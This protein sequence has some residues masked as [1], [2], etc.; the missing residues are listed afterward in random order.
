MPRNV[1][2]YDE[3]C[4]QEKYLWFL[5]EEDLIADFYQTRTNNFS[6]IDTR[7][8]YFYANVGSDLRVVHSGL[9]GLISHGKANLLVNGGI[10]AK[11]LNT[12][13]NE[14]K[15]KTEQLTEILEDNKIKNLIYQSALTL[16][17]GKRFAWKI[18]LDKEVTDKPIVEKY[19]PF[20]YEA[21]YKRN[22]L[23]EI[24]FK[25]KYD[26]ETGFELHEIYGKG[27]I[28]YTLYKIT[29]TGMKE[30]PL[31]Y[32]EETK[33][34]ED[35]E[36]NEKVMLAAEM[37]IEKSDYKGIVSELDALDEAWSQLID[38]I[39][40]ARAETYIPDILMNGKQFDRLRKRY[41]ETST[42]DR[43]GAKNEISHNQP[44][45]R[46]EEY[47]NTIL[48]LRENI[49]ANVGLNAITIGI[50][51]TAGANA[52]GT[53]LEKRETV[54][55]RTREQMIG[56]WETFLTQFY[57]LLLFANV[58]DFIELKQRNFIEE[59]VVVEFGSYITPN[60]E[61]LIEQVKAL[62]DSDLVDHEKALDMLYGDTLSEEERVRILANVGTL[63]FE[64]EGDID[65]EQDTE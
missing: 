21:I 18:S 30:M 1:M 7:A 32:L 61:Q 60:F 28:K 6:I 46:S 25:Q 33:D 42:D 39:R 43:E 13:G 2:N 57:Q 24:I 38:E 40:T 54:S 62:I 16:S 10:E 12:R 31:D 34:L 45:I 11:I 35:V 14:D 52:S 41:V 22:R 48:A 44:D 5:G 65:G 59:N 8:S 9:A 36:W 15:N 50:D 26:Y 63:T 23:H 58:D 27:Y 47:V 55:L 20:N 64:E 29:K 51:D 3:Y 17:W 37:C 19:N 49:L 56:E 4:L 53:A